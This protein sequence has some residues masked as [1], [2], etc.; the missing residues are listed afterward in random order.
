MKNR[1]FFFIMQRIGSLFMYGLFT[2]W[3]KSGGR[4]RK[5]G[6]GIG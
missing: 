1:R 6:T 4:E 2:K 3:R 5:T